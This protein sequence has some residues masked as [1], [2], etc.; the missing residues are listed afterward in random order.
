MKQA[1]GSL[2]VETSCDVEGL[3]NREVESVNGRAVGDGGCR[4]TELVATMAINVHRLA[5]NRQWTL[6]HDGHNIPEW[7]NSC[8]A[9]KTLH[10]S[11]THRSGGG[12]DAS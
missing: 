9:S 3:G 1:T 7:D 4:K 2:L 12:E 8:K 11:E 10:H 6:C 5:S